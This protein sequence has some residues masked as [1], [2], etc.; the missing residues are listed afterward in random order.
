M[1]KE[2]LI[3]K[4]IEQNITLSVAESL[5]GGLLSSSIVEVSCVSKI[6]K[7]SITAYALE[8]KDKLLGVPL[9]HTKTTDGVDVKTAELMAKNVSKLLDSD[10]GI[11]TTGIAEVYDEREL[12]AFISIY[13]R[14]IDLSK[15]FHIIF[16]NKMNR[17]EVR[18]EVVSKVFKALEDSFIF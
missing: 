15:T 18:E 17:Q 11:S 7:G 1:K 10:I 13:N 16:N 8:V 9:S 6:Y 3:K 5:T 2:K 12:Q 4:F 14:K